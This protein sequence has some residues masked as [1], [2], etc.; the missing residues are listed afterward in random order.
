MSGARI[1]PR[2]APS[3][4]VGRLLDLAEQVRRLPP[5]DRRDPER[6]HIAKDDPAAELRRV[7][8]DAERG[9]TLD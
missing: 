9:R 6:F 2:P 8:T 4:I 5:P 7:A 1:L 3:G